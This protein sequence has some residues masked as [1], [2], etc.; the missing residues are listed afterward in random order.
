MPCFLRQSVSFCWI[1]S[2][3]IPS[4]SF[5]VYPTPSLDLR[6]TTP[7]H[8]PFFTLSVSASYSTNAELKTNPDLKFT[9]STQNCIWN[10][11]LQYHFWG[12]RFWFWNFNWSHCWLHSLH[13]LSTYWC[14]GLCCCSISIRRDS[15]YVKTW[16]SCLR[17]LIWYM[18]WTGSWN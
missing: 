18:D 17:V 3:W 7:N 4:V 15:F 5:F 11:F 10:G 9:R 6:I 13:L 14:W 1:P 12:F 16:N 2:L 8:F